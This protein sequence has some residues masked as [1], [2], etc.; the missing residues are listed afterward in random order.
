MEI[1]KI[2][3]IQKQIAE[4]MGVDELCCQTAEEAAELSH[5]LLTL[6]RTRGN[7]QPT[8]KAYNTTVNSVAEEIVDTIICIKEAIYLLNI[9][10][11]LLEFIEDQKI[12]R[13]AKRYGLKGDN[14]D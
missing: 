14:N 10:D 6:R 4:K 2:K 8:D 13:T 11:D 9:S 12:K 1:F 5:A 7:G 3:P